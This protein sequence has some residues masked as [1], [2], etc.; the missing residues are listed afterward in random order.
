MFGGGT[1]PESAKAT[2]SLRDD[3]LFVT[4]DSSIDTGGQAH[5]L[6]SLAD[7]KSELK[8]RRRYTWQ[9][10]KDEVS[11]SGHYRYIYRGQQDSS[12]RLRTAFHRS[13]RFNLRKYTKMYLPIVHQH[14]IP[15]TNIIFDRDNPAQNGAF[16]SLA[17]HHGFPTPL[18]DWSYSPFVAVF[19]AFRGMTNSVALD[20]KSARVFVF[21]KGG[22]EKDL[23]QLQDLFT[24]RRHFSVLET[25]PIENPRMIPQ[26][27]LS[28]VTNLDDIEPY[29]QLLEKEAGKTYL[30]VIDIPHS[31]RDYVLGDLAKMGITAG[32]IFPGLDGVCEQMKDRFFPST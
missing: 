4:W 3:E 14:I 13:G 24:P 1:F 28:T 5:L 32:S 2:L 20:G 7:E 15:H 16:L 22:W 31:N 18:L 9:E 6:R 19:F 8:S 11:E 10:F 27:A 25:L 30:R 26:Q 21:D 12:W 17:Q 23:P 29:I